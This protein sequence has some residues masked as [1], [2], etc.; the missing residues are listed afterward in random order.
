MY[1]YWWNL[2]QV[3]S[4]HQRRIPLRN[5]RLNLSSRTS[6]NISQL[7]PFMPRPIITP[8]PFPTLSIVDVT[9]DSCTY[10]IDYI[11]NCVKLDSDWDVRYCNLCSD[12]FCVTRFCHDCNGSDYFLFREVC[13]CFRRTAVFSEFVSHKEISKLG[14]DPIFLDTIHPCETGLLHN[15]LVSNNYSHVCVGIYH[16]KHLAENELIYSVHCRASVLCDKYNSFNFW[17]HGHL[18]KDS[19]DEGNVLWSLYTGSLSAPNHVCKHSKD[20][21]QR[22]IDDILPRTWVHC[23]GCSTW[24]TSWG[25]TLQI[26][27]QLVFE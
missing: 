1:L 24:D 9:F 15:V 5:M 22:A 7:H 16:V 23:T 17:P 18:W 2:R 3:T 26:N 4:L 25:T 21:V 6:S 13:I 10:D 27:H 19:Y 8:T 14:Y 20:K 12:C 11:E